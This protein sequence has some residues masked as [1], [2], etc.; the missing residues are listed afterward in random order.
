MHLLDLTVASDLS[1]L[2]LIWLWRSFNSIALLRSSTESCTEQWGHHS[3]R[4]LFNICCF[5]WFAGSYMF[6]L[7]SSLSHHHLDTHTQTPVTAG[8]MR[9]WL[10]VVVCPFITQHKAPT[11]FHSFWT[12]TVEDLTFFFFVFFFH[13]DFYVDMFRQG[14]QTFNKTNKKKSYTQKITAN[15]HTQKTKQCQQTL[16]RVKN[17]I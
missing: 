3:C 1:P 15:N 8:E 11:L 14:H 13:S 12:Q 16:N 6:L 7:K 10:V 4:R 5:I 2:T 17:R 9:T